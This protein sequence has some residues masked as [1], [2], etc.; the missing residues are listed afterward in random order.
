[1]VR[2]P[3]PGNDPGVAIKRGH[4]IQICDTEGSFKTGGIYGFKKPSEIASKPAGEWNHYTVRC[5]GPRVEVWCNGRQ[6]LDT[7]IDRY[8]TLRHPPLR[9]YFGLQ[10][11]GVG[12]SFRNL[13]YLRLTPGAESADATPP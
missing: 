3:D 10:N 4:E 9:G 6:V 2:F 13:R 1:M 8:P 5:R 7:R 12:A 11:H